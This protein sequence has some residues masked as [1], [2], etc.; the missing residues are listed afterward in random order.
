ML[1]K[2]SLRKRL[3]IGF[4]A[5][6]FMLLLSNV[7]G[8]QKVNYISDSLT[9]ITDVNSLKQRYAINFRGSVHDRAISVRDVVLVEK[10]DEIN[11]LKQE[12]KTLKSF[13]DTS[14]SAMKA[15]MNDA[16]LFSAK[17]LD[18]ISRINSIR[19]KT[20]P[21][22]KQIIALKEAGNDSE[23]KQVLLE[24]AKPAFVTWLAVINEFIDHQEQKNQETTPLARDV[25]DGF[26]STML[27]ITAIAAALC[28]LIAKLIIDNLYKAL[29]AEPSDAAQVVAT[30]ARGDL[31]DRVE[32]KHSNS[33]LYSI[34]EMQTNLTS[35]VKSIKSAANEVSEQSSHL[36]DTSKN[37]SSDASTQA[38]L[39]SRT[40]S[41]LEEMQTRLDHIAEIAMQTEQNSK[42]TTEFSKKGTLAVS[43][44]ANEIESISVT[45]NDTVVQVRKLESTVKEIG[46]IVG[47]ISSI[48]E[49]TNLLALNAAIEAARAGETGRGFA[50]VADEVRT[51]AGRTGDATNQIQAIITELQKETIASVNAMEKTQPLVEN[52]KA[53]T[54]EANQILIDIEKQAL[55][56]LKNVQSVVQATHSQV[57]S[58][59]EIAQA[60]EQIKGMS[61]R[62]IHSLDENLAAANGLNLVSIDL[63][64]K[65]EFFKV[66]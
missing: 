65:V 39:T 12:I 26:Q 21:L 42:E 45:V 8:I 20:L 31:T 30:M 7:I 5:A 46:A 54:S 41:N 23:A 25:A 63:R 38:D 64:D 60:M 53:L 35:I 50:V 2:M 43:R 49:Q 47:V 58:I 6:L 55:E 66:S 24:Q 59:N 15:M 27:I 37:V 16:S 52:G 40:L 29:G 13:Y 14:N 9:E 3:Y 1:N 61:E 56:S 28:L 17:E 22:I 34:K 11:A 51:L 10:P 18:I 19:D 32:S 36:Q 4:S 33:M 62:T 57:S 48:S 44:S